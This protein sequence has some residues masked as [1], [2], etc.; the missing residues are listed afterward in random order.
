MTN[1]TPDKIYPIN[2]ITDIDYKI[3]IYREDDS[4]IELTLTEYKYIHDAYE[5]FA[6]QTGFKGIK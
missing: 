4:E 2:N 5:I 1:K 3:V 6:K